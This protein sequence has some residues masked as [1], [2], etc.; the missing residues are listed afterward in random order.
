MNKKIEVQNFSD[1]QSHLIK[2]RRPISLLMGNGFSVAF[3]KKYSHI[4]H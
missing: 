3:D 1:V 2:S 4:M